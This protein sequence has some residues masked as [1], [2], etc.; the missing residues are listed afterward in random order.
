MMSKVPHGCK[1]CRRG[2]VIT[3]IDDFSTGDKVMFNPESREP[4]VN[5][6]LRGKKDNSCFHSAWPSWGN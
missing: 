3:N 2:K 1:D 6:N 5:D 4:D